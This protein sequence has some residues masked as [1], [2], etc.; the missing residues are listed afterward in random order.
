M[1]IHT[2]LAPMST[3][4]DIATAVSYSF[5]SESLIFRIVTKNGLQRG[6]ELQWLSAFPTEEEILFPPLTYLQPTGKTQ[7]IELN[8]LENKYR[9]T[10]VEVIPTVA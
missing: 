3:T 2:Q 8:K 10:I 6:A 5:S 4:T 9:F 1:R 7:L